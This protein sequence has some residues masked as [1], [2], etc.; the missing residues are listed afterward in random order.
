[1]TRAHLG[2]TSEIIDYRIYY[3]INFSLSHLNHH[4]SVFFSDLS[5]VRRSLHYVIFTIMLIL[6][7]VVFLLPG[8]WS[9]WSQPTTIYSPC[10]NLPLPLLF[11]LLLYLSSAPIISTTIILAQ[12]APV[13]SI[14]LRQPWSASGRASWASASAHGS[15]STA[16]PS[17]AAAH[18]A[19]AA[20]CLRY[21]CC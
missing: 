8:T 1:M 19:T 5:L 2:S 17:S 21:C 20:S 9:F 13:V 10:S 4:L 7:A 11:H 18:S 12:G 15:A 16:A 14:P 3:I 6:Y